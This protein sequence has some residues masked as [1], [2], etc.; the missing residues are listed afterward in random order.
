VELVLVSYY[1]LLA[2]LFSR[3]F[4]VIVNSGLKGIGKEAVVAF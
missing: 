3:C 4:E 2:R 1:Y